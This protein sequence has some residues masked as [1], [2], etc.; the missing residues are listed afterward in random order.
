RVA[1]VVR[2]PRASHPEAPSC[3]SSATSV[4]RHGQRPVTARASPAVRETDVEGR[5]GAIALLDVVALRPEVG[6]VQDVLDRELRGELAVADLEGFA[7]GEVELVA[8]CEEDVREP[9]H[10]EVVE[11]LGDRVVE[12]TGD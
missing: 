11:G 4:L 3:Q 2:R 1:R 8:P 12:E 9:A 5:A 6:V 10:P 7:P